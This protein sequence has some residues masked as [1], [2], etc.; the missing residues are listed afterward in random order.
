VEHR[1]ESL[2]A[3]HHQRRAQRREDLEGMLRT[4]NLRIRHRRL[5]AR[6]QRRH[7]MTRLFDRHERVAIAVHHQ[8]RRRLLADRG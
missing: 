4:R 7:E 6:P 2:D 8:K 5:G 1:D 3:V